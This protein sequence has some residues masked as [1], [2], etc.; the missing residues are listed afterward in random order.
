MTRMS[1]LKN[2]FN[3]IARKYKETI[4]KYK[5]SNSSI[6]VISGGKISIG[7]NVIIT[8]SKIYIDGT[9]SLILGDNTTIDGVEIRI[10]NGGK[11]SIDTHSIIKRERNP[12]VPEI[13]CDSGNISISDHSLLQAERIW[14]RY[15]GEL[16]I[17]QYTNINHGSEIRCD[18]K[19][20]IGS[21]CGISYYVRIWDTNTHEQISTEQ[22]RKRRID[23]FPYLGYEKNRPKTKAVIIDDDSWIGEKVGIL[24]GTIIGKHVTV[25]FGTILVN[26]LVQ[27]DYIVVQK[28]EIKTFHHKQKINGQD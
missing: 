20:S 4:W 3:R 14:V 7:K 17:G 8:N 22:R 9:S 21:F 28:C 24:K 10:T 12:V 13:I 27:P 16:K 11:I 6:R 2:I 19:I 26:E 15:G 18:E 5:L 1:N 25:G 23:Y